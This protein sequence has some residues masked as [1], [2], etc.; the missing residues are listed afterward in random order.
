MYGSVS[1]LVEFRHAC[2]TAWGSSIFDVTLETQ[3]H[4][5][6]RARSMNTGWLTDRITF[7]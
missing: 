3:A 4:V 7:H 2:L 5:G 1:K 6:S